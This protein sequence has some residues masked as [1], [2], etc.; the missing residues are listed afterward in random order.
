MLSGGFNVGDGFTAMKGGIPLRV[1]GQVI[2][3]I[4]VSGTASADQDE[5]IAK[6]VVEKW[7]RGSHGRASD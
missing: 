6:A 1:R 7:E 2:G 3:A 4:G 5:Q